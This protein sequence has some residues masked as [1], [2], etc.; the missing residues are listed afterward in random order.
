MS[1]M[2]D[3]TEYQGGGVLP[4]TIF[5]KGNDALTPSDKL[6]LGYITGQDEDSR[7]TPDPGVFYGNAYFDPNERP[8]P[9]PARVARERRARRIESQRYNETRR[10]N[11]HGN[12]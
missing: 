4:N 3:R 12:Y 8:R 6:R 9:D 2:S 1:D 10:P 11:N 7:A 5:P